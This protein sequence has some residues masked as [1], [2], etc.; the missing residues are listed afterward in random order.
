MGKWEKGAQGARH[1]P[2]A[3]AQTEQR[4]EGALAEAEDS[5]SCE[6]L[7]MTHAKICT[8]WKVFVIPRST[9]TLVCAD[10]LLGEQ[11]KGR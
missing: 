11:K 8:L 5:S 9:C 7:T 6:A 4:Y 3:H 10:P 1:I 2:G